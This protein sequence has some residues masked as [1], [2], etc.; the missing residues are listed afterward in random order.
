[1]LSKKIKQNEDEGYLNTP[2]KDLIEKAVYLIRQ[3]KA[4]TKFVWVKGHA[5]IEGNEEADKMA[6]IGRLEEMSNK[7][8]VTI[9]ENFRVTGARLRG[10]PFKLLYKGTLNSYKKPVRATKKH[11]GIREDIKDEIERI[12]G[13]RPTTEAIFKGVRK[14]PIQNKVGDFIWK[15]IH[16]CNKCGRYFAHWRPEAQYC[17]C[18]DLETVEHILMQCDQ[19][20]I[21]KVWNKIGEAWKTLTGKKWPGV[22]I[23]II[24]G[25]GCIQLESSYQ[26]FWYKVLVSETVWALWKARNQR[27]WSGKELDDITILDEINRNINNRMYIDW[28]EVKWYKKEN[29][30]RKKFE[31]RWCKNNIPG[32]IVDNK[33]KA[34]I[35]GGRPR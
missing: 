13:N 35:I 7:L 16:D 15:C 10:L 31:S 32:K 1:M 24:R 25:I 21:T 12:S 5:G 4:P 28:E 3:R 30:K 8:E 26:T 23:G 34:Y 20:E 6:D 9:P 19:S 11:E 27:V 33:L 18:G 22:S 29:I 14:A 2:N 17:H